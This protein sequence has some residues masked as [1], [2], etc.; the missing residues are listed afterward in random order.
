MTASVF[1]SSLEK[2]YLDV[3]QVLF[4]ASGIYIEVDNCYHKVDAI[5]LD[6]EENRYYALKKTKEAEWRCPE[7]RNYNYPEVNNCRVCGWPW[8][9]P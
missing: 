8:G 9:S 5:A 1:G 4:D 2:I 7:Y 3:D 6:K